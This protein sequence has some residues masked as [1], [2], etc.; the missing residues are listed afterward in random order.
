MKKSLSMM[1]SMLIIAMMFSG[2]GGG[3]DGGDEEPQKSCPPVVTSGADKAVEEEQK[4][5]LSAG[6]VSW[7]GSANFKW[8][9]ASGLSVSLENPGSLNA[10]SFIAPKV[11]AGK[12]QE[13]LIFMFSLTDSDGHVA[14]TTAK[15]I[16]YPKGFIAEKMELEKLYDTL[17]DTSI[18]YEGKLKESEKQGVLSLINNIRTLHKLPNVVYDASQDSNTAKAALMIA[19]NNETNHQPNSG[20]YCFSDSGAYGLSKSMLHINAYQ[21]SSDIQDSS[22]PIMFFLK[23]EN[24]EFLGQRRGILDPFLKGI[25]FGRSDGKTRTENFWNAT[26]SALLLVSDPKSDISGI[27]ISFVAY[28]YQDYPKEYFARDGYFSFSVIA[29]YKEAWKNDL[30]DFSKASVQISDESGI[31]VYIRSIGFDNLFYGIPNIL[32]WKADTI[33]ENK[34]YTVRIQ[35]VIVNGESVNYEYKFRLK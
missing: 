17:P 19:A 32:K 13:N 28:P 2:C 12:E 21:K 27:G 1:F 3:G 24:T 6:N 20:D 35:N 23:D 9:Q 7:C 33:A 31:S 14:S 10:A 25:S 18:C 11:T 8:S 16:V 34:L 26:G 22:A 30:V 4:V 15:V 5:T 29:N